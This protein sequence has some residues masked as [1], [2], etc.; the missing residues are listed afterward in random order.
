MRHL[1][2]KRRVIPAT[3]TNALSLPGTGT[4]IAPTAGNSR[5][6]DLANTSLSILI[7]ALGVT[8]EL[9]SACPQLQM[10]VGA[11][12]IALEAYKKYS[13]ATEAIGSLL[14]RIHSL[15][16][17]LN[18]VQSADRCP[19]SLKDRLASL[20][21]LQE[22]T[23]EA[24][25][26]RSKRRI[27]QFLNATNNTERIE[28]WIKKLDQHIN[29][30]LVEGIFTLELTVHA[31]HQDL[32]A[33][34]D[35]PTGTTGETARA[36]ANEALRKALRPV[37][38]ALLHSG[39]SVHVQCHEDTRHEVLST[40]RSWLQPDHPPLSDR[41][42]LW[43]HALA[44]S[45]KST[46][47]LTIANRW[48][49]D[50]LLG[51]SFF[52]AR[53][54]DRSNV[55][56]IFRTI[57]YQL[58]LRFPAFRGHLTMILETEPD[59]YS[60]TPTRQLEKLIVEPLEAARADAKREAP[61]PAHI[62]IVIDALDECTDTA[63]VSIVLKSLASYIARL[64]PLKFLITSRPEENIARGFLLQNIR[65]NT[66]DLALNEIPKARTRRDIS[67]Y[68]RS[69]LAEI[70][71]N[72]ALYASWP[73][74]QQLEN[75]V[76]LSEL[77][78]I[79]A[80][81]AARYIGDTAARDPESRLTSLLDA[82]NAAAAKRGTSTSPF[83]ILDALYIQVLENAA[84]H[85]ETELK[86]RLKLILGT[87][88]LAEQRLTPTTLD[89]LLDLEAGTVRRVLPVLGAVLTIP[90]RED[91]TTP[92]SIIHLSFPN[93]LI[94]PTRCTDKGFL[95]Q[96]CI[97]HFHIA[98]RCLNLM[99]ELKYNILGHSSKDDCVL[100]SE[101]PDLLAN[102]SHHIPPALQYA[103]KYW[104]RHLCGAEVSEDLLTALEEFCKFRLLHW[105]EALSLLGCVD[106]AVDAL[107]SV[108]AFL[109]TQ[110]LRATDVPSLLYDCER[111]VR[112]FYPIISISAM[113][114]YSTIALFA[115]H[116]SPLRRLAAENA[117][118]SLVVRVGVEDTWSTTLVSC[119][120]DGS[121][122]EVLAFSPNGACIAYGTWR[123]TIQ[124]LNAH[125]GAELQ[126]FWNHANISSI[127]SLSFSPTGKELLSGS[128]DGTV[129]V[130]DI[131]TGAQLNTWEAHTDW[132]HSVA[133]SPNDTL[134]ASASDDGTV[135]LWR[136]ASPEKMVVLRHSYRVEHVVF[137]PDG[138]LLSGSGDETCK[139]WETRSIGWDSETDIEPIR[140]L[141]HHS[142]VCTVAVSPDSCMVACG[143]YNG[144]IILWTK[145]DGQQVGSLPGR[146]EVVSLVFYPSGLLAAA[147]YSSPITLWDVL[148]GARVK[149]ASNEGAWAAAF[150]LDG[151]HIAHATRNQLQIHLWPSEVKQ[152]AII[153]TSF[154][155][156]LNQLARGSTVEDREPR[157]DRQ[158]D[159][160][161]IAR[162]PTWKLVL[163]VYD[164]VLRIFEVSTGRC[165]RTIHHSSGAFS[166]ATWSPTGS[167][168]AC[169][170]HDHTVRVW[171]TDTGELVRTFTGHSGDVTGVVF[172]PDEQHIPSASDDRTIRRGK[173]GQNGQQMTSDVLFQSDGYHIVAFAVSSDG[174]WIL[175]AA[176][177]PSSPPDTSNAD[178]LVAPSRQPV[179]DEDGAYNALRLHDATTGRVLW[180]EHL[181]SYIRSVA[182]SEDCTRALAGNE[183]GEVFLYDL[184]QIIPPDNTVP[185]SPHPLAVPEHKLSVQVADAIKRICFSP[186]GRAAIANSTYISIPPGLQPL[187]VRT[188]NRCSTPF[189]F[190]EEDWLWRVNL[191][192]D[193]RRLCWVPPSFRPHEE[194]TGSF[195]SPGGQPIAYIAL[196]GSLVTMDDASAC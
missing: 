59:L 146:S 98:S 155:G 5:G 93:F 86:D 149:I 29:D 150:A 153:A 112:A 158:T 118:T 131:A 100:N 166:C 170:G 3:P 47:A 181:P 191:D 60:S 69:C 187:I 133:W 147:Y 78:F 16:E 111:A 32:I 139:I 73:A 135:R 95:V 140:T 11:L 121:S 45:G 10:A 97:Q 105:L 190:Y 31:V 110:S 126:V 138:D 194:S 151:L 99:Q 132:V 77:L 152:K 125:T 176:D 62:A 35:K 12:L 178:L 6:K 39:T 113:H 165:M 164:H 83:P 85:L 175:S 56:C 88:V 92:I 169:I 168:F 64:P 124:L 63:A 57:A 154:T 159:L 82:G 172:T 144:K 70:R 161:A 174:R 184:T 44:G 33:M 79:F 34:S 156:K 50:K 55:N 104:T 17:K 89:A 24:G 90:S 145:S 130:W 80:A 163:A 20:A 84:R 123:G 2:A 116:D 107:Q 49:N 18:K 96:P 14:S 65:E 192:S 193:P 173:I 41:S 75:L 26:V 128:R 91:D 180:I 72:F 9:S 43:L 37:V 102:I 108:Q 171:K 119:V 186:N 46:I 1:R 179:K 129:N 109:N 36:Q 122:I 27:V 167:L 22:V 196:G 21:R 15:N 61:F 4:E 120:D 38:E 54:G 40:L 13:D 28:S 48:D 87:I 136:V 160:R 67:L 188:P 106:D 183:E 134:A 115:P 7:S 42:I 8:K 51:A 25:K 94:D 185:R 68:L 162:S 141:K 23:E 189:F 30:F 148:T 143:L 71:D 137:A 101:I 195:P 127:R 142:P 76:G 58:S 157:G 103:C 74:P 81:A 114:M 177:R 19:Q 66:Q 182:F 52:C 53:D 117:R